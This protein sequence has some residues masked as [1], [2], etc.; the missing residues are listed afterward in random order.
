MSQTQAEAQ[1]PEESQA[2][3]EGRAKCDCPWCALSEAT[4]RWRKESKT[5]GHFHNAQIE[6][7]KG[8]RAFFDEC[9]TRMEKEASEPEPRVSKI[10]V[11]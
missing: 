8:I 2:G 11:E 5:L 4:R 3:E 6:V 1:A 9:V 10:E 7:L